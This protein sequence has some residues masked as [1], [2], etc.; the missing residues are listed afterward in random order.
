MELNRPN[1]PLAPPAQPMDQKVIELVKQHGARKW[2]QIAQQLPGRISSSAAKRWHNHLN[3]E[4]SK[5]AW[6]E[7]EDRKILSSHAKL[8]NRWAEIAKLLP[9]RTDNAIK[10]HWNSS[11]KRKYERFLE[12]S[13]EKLVVDD[14]KALAAAREAKAAL[15]AAG[16]LPGS[17]R[18]KGDLAAG[19]ASS[20]PSEDGGIVPRF[21]V[22][23]QLDDAIKAACQA[24][25]SA[26]D[27]KRAPGAPRRRGRRASARRAR[28]A[29]GTA[30]T[31]RSRR[32]RAVAGGGR[33]A[34]AAPLEPQVED[35]GARE[36]RVG[37]ARREPAA[38]RRGP[39]AEPGFGDYGADSVMLS[40]TQLESAVG[41]DFLP[42]SGD[43]S[44]RSSYGSESS[45]LGGCDG[46]AILGATVEAPG[47]G[48]TRHGARR[49]RSRR[50]RHS[51]GLSLTMADVQLGR[52]SGA[53]EGR[54][55]AHGPSFKKTRTVLDDENAA[56]NGAAPMSND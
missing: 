24:P 44:R 33:G 29:T 52:V 1:P 47:L 50:P 38:R 42:G 56:E 54:A 37:G 41:L 32:R 10:N 49:R 3:P 25:R 51:T 8:G 16:V 20:A 19:A 15:D 35:G 28:P 45:S 18:K 53:F 31:R 30:T 13:L 6:T 4:I 11:I 17:R 23:R 14:D 34:R 7:E 39:G 22:G 21:L 40:P 5:A 46:D 27:T 43:A 26:T 48:W 55:P 2:S 36:P 12:D 9:G